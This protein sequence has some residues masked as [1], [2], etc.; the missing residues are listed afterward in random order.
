MAR[1]WRK[2]ATGG[3]ALHLGEQPV[4]YVCAGAVE[5]GEPGPWSAWAM[6]QDGTSGIF[7]AKDHPTQ[8]AAKEYAE[9]QVDL[10]LLRA[11][12]RET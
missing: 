10:W 1:Q 2:T 3:Q 5:G 6:I 4:A 12:L 8:L 11:E 7:P 9:R